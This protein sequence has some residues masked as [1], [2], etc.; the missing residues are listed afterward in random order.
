MTVK[1][2]ANG[3][4]SFALAAGDWGS[5]RT[6]DYFFDMQATDKGSPIETLAKSKS[7]IVQDM[8]KVQVESRDFPATQLPTLRILV[9]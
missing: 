3:Q 6:D 7:D 9:S 1:D 8:S 5:I 2:A 4:V